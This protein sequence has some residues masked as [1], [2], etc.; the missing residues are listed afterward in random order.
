MWEASR[1]TQFHIRAGDTLPLHSLQWVPD[2]PKWGSLSGSQQLAPS[3]LLI[4]PGVQVLGQVQGS[5]INLFTGTCCVPGALTMAEDAET[6]QERT[7]YIRSSSV[8]GQ[9]H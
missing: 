3:I 8:V 4:N 5:S 1:Q 2:E 6:E 9:M 7:L